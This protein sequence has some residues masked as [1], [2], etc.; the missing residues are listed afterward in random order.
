MDLANAYCE[1]ILKKMCEQIIKKG[2][3]TDNVAMLY[4]A[5]IKFE[6]KVWI[7]F[8]WIL[9]L[10]QSQI[11]NNEFKH[12]KEEDTHTDFFVFL[13][14]VKIWL[15]FFPIIFKIIIVETKYLHF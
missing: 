11:K 12:E 3:T 2:M 4:A 1:P 15:K 9:I 13:Y 5:A 6:A 14:K 8:Q 7:L 10:L